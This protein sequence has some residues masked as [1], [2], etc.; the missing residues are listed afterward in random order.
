MGRF[1]SNKNDAIIEELKSKID[2]LMQQNS[3]LKAKI[4]AIEH[5]GETPEKDSTQPPQEPTPV[6]GKPVL[7]DENTTA[8]EV[9]TATV[10]TPEP[11]AEESKPA[12]AEQSIT[13]EAP[14]TP[15]P[16]AI[17]SP[18]N[19]VTPT[20]ESNGQDDK[21]E[22]P[23]P[24]ALP[25]E[26]IDMLKKVDSHLAETIYKDN[27]IKDIHEELQ[28]HKI[29]LR[30]EFVKPVIKDIILLYDTVKEALD[31]NPQSAST[32]PAYIKLYNETKNTLYAIEDLLFAYDI[33]PVV[34]DAGTPFDPKTQKALKKEQP[35]TAE[36][37]KTIVRM[38]KTGFKSTATGHMMR[39]VTVVVYSN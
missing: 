15:S 2:L 25:Q 7:S 31:N 5:P 19:T 8:D 39:D 18:V 28:Q 4:D 14:A 11:V 16:E 6:H 27:L 23:I 10:P 38:L 13:T 9:Q 37:D 29:G 22:K 26:V 20:E 34:A 12:S 36:Q 30:Q 35:P 32:D 3:D 24:Q 1:L 21:H 33:E 17:P